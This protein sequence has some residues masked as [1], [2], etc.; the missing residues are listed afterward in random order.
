MVPL[1]ISR[2]EPLHAHAPRPLD[3]QPVAAADAPVGAQFL[4]PVGH[5]ARFGKGAHPLGLQ[6]DPAGR[7]S[8]GLG[9]GAGD[10]KKIVAQV[11][12]QDADL[13]VQPLAVR[14]QF[15][16][17]AQGGQVTASRAEGGHG[18]QTGGHGGGVG[19]VGIVD[20]PQP[21]G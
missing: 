8:H 14:A 13:A 19:V 5:Q 15:E 12:D 16:H 9:L 1:V 3:E 17:V 4:Q 6:T 20:H 11:R 10:R 2:P 21:A 7:I 18:A